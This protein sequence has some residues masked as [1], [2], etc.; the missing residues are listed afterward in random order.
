MSRAVYQVTQQNP[1]G[2]FT[3]FMSSQSFPGKKFRN[4]GDT[5]GALWILAT[6]MIRETI[7]N[8]QRRM[9]PNGTLN[10]D[11]R[12]PT[13]NRAV[14]DVWMEVIL[15]FV[16]GVDCNNTQTSISKLNHLGWFALFEFNPTCFVDTVLNNLIIAVTNADKKMVE[17]IIQ[18]NP[19]YLTYK[20]SEGITAFQAALYANDNDMCAMMKIYFEKLHGG[21]EEMRQQF[22]ELFPDGYEA[23]LKKQNKEAEILLGNTGINENIFK[24]VSPTDVTNALNNI[25]NTTSILHKKLAEFKN[26]FVEK[27]IKK[28]KA[29]NPFILEKTYGIYEK[30]YGPWSVDQLHLFSQQVIGFIQRYSSKIWQQHYAQGIY[31]L[32]EK[33]EQQQR[34]FFLAGTT[35]DIRSLDKLGFE[36]CIDV[37]G[38]DYMPLLQIIKHS[39]QTPI[40]SPISF[41]YEKQ[42]EQKNTNILK[43]M[44]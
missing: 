11:N 20:N 26:I 12:A 42:V 3:L 44:R 31:N 19:I 39:L 15:P 2:A 8:P 32:V 29:H 30:N 38:C 40:S 10:L 14:R 22:N 27:Y 33:N 24:D 9:L 1:D 23:H 41:F 37:G 18:A 6:L 34:S 25:P 21:L 35:T 16:F 17:C 13:I 7:N 28:N 43:L 4:M 5:S 36:Y